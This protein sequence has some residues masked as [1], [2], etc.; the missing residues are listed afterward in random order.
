MNLKKNDVAF[1]V[2]KPLKQRRKNNSFDG[3]DNIG[4]L[5]II[6]ALNCGGIDVGFCSPETAHNF[7]IVLVSLTSTYDVIAFYKSVAIMPQWQKSKRAFKVVAG[8]FGMQ[9]PI[10]IRNYIDY[11]VFGRAHDF[12]CKIIDLLLGGG[13]VQHESVMCLP[14]IHNV[15][16]AQAPLYEN[17]IHFKGGVWREAFT[18]CPRKCK[19][20]YFTWSRKS[21]QNSCD[22]S[23]S[24]LTDGKSP[25][26]TWD[27]MML[28][29]KKAG[30]IR[31][32]IDG[33]SERLR[34]AYGKKISNTDII[35][36]IEHLGSF[37]GNATVLTAYNISNMPRE[38]ESDRLELYETIARAKP[39]TRVIL[40]LQSTPFR[41]SLA[42][43]MQ[44]C[45]VSLYPA[46]S[47]LSASVI[48][49]S[50]KL[51]AMHSFSNE[52]P[53]SQLETVIIERATEATDKLFY[54]ICFSPR[55]KSLS[56]KEAIS[57]IKKNF[58]LTQ[59]LRRYDPEEKHPAWFLN[60]YISRDKIINISKK[61]ELKMAAPTVTL[62]NDE[63]E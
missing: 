49:D 7:R 25:E 1:L 43:P 63:V 21:T 30:R 12:I 29:E 31:S 10:T 50:P 8:G 40:V 11:A 9:N 23:Q 22:Y 6:D 28:I 27:Q 2:Y 57:V 33:F 39:K 53:Y 34:F 18:G 56:S 38:N 19:F 24:I 58:D 3:N 5:V 26:L 46:T 62:Q 54:A 61:M 35:N 4:A 16:I 51:R 32:A 48:F 13:C 36:G 60:G 42:T 37:G 45:E 15:K 55:L 47:S 59:Y 44:H 14:D 17:K 52:S 41:P 20:C